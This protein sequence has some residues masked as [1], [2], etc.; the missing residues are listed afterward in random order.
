MYV[1]H[2]S[3]ILSRRFGLSVRAIITIKCAE[4]KFKIKYVNFATDLVIFLKFMEN[5]KKK[6]D[7][8]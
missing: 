1:N 4:E 8:C 5:N 7:Q 2:C 6:C 3:L